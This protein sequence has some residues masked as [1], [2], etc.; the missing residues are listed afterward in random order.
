MARTAEPHSASSQFFINHT[1]NAGLNRDQARDGWG[2]CVFGKVT[3]GLAVL[4]AIAD[5]AT[6]NKAGHANVPN[7]P[8]VIK[9]V[10]RDS[11]SAS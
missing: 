10:R 11:A 9:S 6:G 3:D 8:V 5:V 2:Y 7:E 1:D 4:D